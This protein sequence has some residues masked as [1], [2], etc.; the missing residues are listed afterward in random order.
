MALLLLSRLNSCCI[1]SLC[2]IA[3]KERIF[4]FFVWLGI[5]WFLWKH[6]W[7]L[8]FVFNLKLSVFKTYSIIHSNAEWLNDVC[9][10][11][12]SVSSEVA[13]V[14][15]SGQNARQSLHNCIES[16]TRLLFIAEL[17]PWG[18]D[19]TDFC[20]TWADIT[21]KTLICFV[22]IFPYVRS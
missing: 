14:G 4:H 8:S 20:I 19:C 18:T 5:R 22:F 9:L 21:H 3:P 6:G 11:V 10:S 16:L 12:S 13:K 7:K 17:Q 2:L 1:N 15:K